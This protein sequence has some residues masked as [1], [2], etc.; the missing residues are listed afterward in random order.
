MRLRLAPPFL[1][2]LVLISTTVAC[3]DESSPD[4]DGTGGATSAT[5]TGGAGSGTTASGGTNSFEDCLATMQIIDTMCDD[6]PVGTIEWVGYGAGKCMGSSGSTDGIARFLMS[7]NDVDPDG[8]PTV[9]GLRLEPMTAPAPQQGDRVAF[10]RMPSHLVT[11]NAP[12]PASLGGSATLEPMLF[13]GALG[14]LQDATNEASVTLTAPIPLDELVAGGETR[15]TFHLV[16]GTFTLLQGS[17]QVEVPDQE[18][19]V[20]GCFAVPYELHAIELD[21]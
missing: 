14:F 2:P 20:V 5:G 9:L 11:P 4:D 6:E 21:R 7:M 15:G 18:G 13:G 3:D 8:N 16:G 17:E 12:L 19:E 10:E 1:L